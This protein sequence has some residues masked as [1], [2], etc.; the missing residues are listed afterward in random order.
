MSSSE[1][2][3]TRFSKSSQC[4]SIIAWM[5]FFEATCTFSSY[6]SLK[7]VE[8]VAEHESISNVLVLFTTDIPFK[9]FE[10]YG[11]I[12]ALLVSI[13]GLLYAAKFVKLVGKAVPEIKNY[14]VL[15]SWFMFIYMVSDLKKVD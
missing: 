2:L 3:F 6:T 14:N 12:A 4:N 10:F 5:I 7:H 15:C 13:T 11:L 8:A 1:N 9:H